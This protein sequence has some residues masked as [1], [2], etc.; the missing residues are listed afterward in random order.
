MVD[1]ALFL[2][3]FNGGG[4]ERVMVTLAEGLTPMVGA[5]ELVVLA[6]SGPVRKLVP[7]SLPVVCV[8]RAG[9]DPIT[10][11]VRYLHARKPRT[12]LAAYDHMCVRPLMAAHAARSAC[13][14]YVTV[15]VALSRAWASLRMPC[16]EAQNVKVWFPRASGIICVS[17]G[18]ADDLCENVGV[19][20]GRVVVIGNPIVTQ[21]L[22][23]SSDER[24]GEPW[25]DDGDC[26]V[27]LGVGR[28]TRSKRF[29]VLI[30]A[31]ARMR[32]RNPVRLI[33]LGEGDSGPDLNGLACALGIADDV[34]FVGYVPRPSAFL[35]RAAVV[36]LASE[37][38]GLPSV[39]IEALAVGTPVVAADCPAGPREILD[40]GRWGRL[41]PVGDVDALADALEA[42]IVEGHA[43]AGAVESMRERFS[44]SG[45]V[46]AYAR[47][48]LG[49]DSRYQ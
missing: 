8:G 16:H 43:P 44:E 2:P 45:A 15:H 42:S 35:R 14:V 23:D 33:I 25:L 18:V 19:P 29:D 9:R 31:V 46:G 39:L 11:L 20:R 40:G 38:E 17:D 36:G 7:D 49:A 27:V 37:V 30:H 5:A 47:T 41:V 28:L 26:P 10:G 24:T 34:R 3:D 32:T 1:L 21:R 6:E 12:M 22:I 4:A 13:A 48:I